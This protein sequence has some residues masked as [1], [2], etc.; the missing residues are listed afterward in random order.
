MPARPTRTLN[1]LPFGDLEPRRFEDLVRQLAYDLRTWKSLEATG[2]SGADDGIDIRGIELHT[3]GGSGAEP[4]NDEADAL[5][6]PTERLWI[7]QC[8]REKT[9]E[10]NRIR[11]AIDESIGEGSASPHGFVLAVAADVSKRARDV[12]RREMVKRGV[13]EFQ[14][15]AR[16]EL[17]DMLFQAKNDR[18]LFA[19]FGLSLQPRRRSLATELRAGI[20]LK[21]QLTALFEKQDAGYG[22][23]LV[24]LRD[25]R[26]EYPPF[27]P[28]DLRGPHWAVCEVVHLKTPGALCVLWR[29][30]AAWVRDHANAWDVLPGDEIAVH[31][32]RNTLRSK[33][34]W[35]ADEEQVDRTGREFWEEYVPDAEK[36]WLK[37]YGFVELSRVLAVD[38]IGD[39]YFPIPQLLM[40]FD[41]E[42]GPLRSEKLYRFHPTR[43]DIQRPFRTVPSPKT[44][45]SLF[46]RPIP[47]KLFPPP[48]AFTN[49]VAKHTV[50]L[51][52]SVSDAL[53]ALVRTIQDRDK[54]AQSGSMRE[55]EPQDRTVSK[56]RDAFRE[57][58]R[59][60]GVPVFQ[61]FVADLEAG[62]QDARIQV[63]EGGADE[64]HY[65]TEA[66]SLRVRLASGF[67][68]NPGYRAPGHVRVIFQPWDGST[69]IEIAPTDSQ[70]RSGSS[71][72]MKDLA[73]FSKEHLEAEVVRMHERVREQLSR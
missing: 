73:Q 20:T 48:P 17:E 50:A 3:E 49:P 1:P 16:G 15:W 2:R 10:P 35:I 51:T 62:G 59:S 52:P 22:E 67:A 38:P 9:F 21:K 72:R 26:A 46:P 42:H 25:A 27:G 14:I 70:G 47:E 60:I 68:M 66:V 69:V 32:A 45:A 58:A 6:L 31:G 56:G 63:E 18:L 44:R 7:F 8:K 28:P 13:Q 29:E 71:T 36:A 65:G 12:F 64:F 57:W 23:K 39:G 33:H 43:G 55:P 30:S 5:L 11:K 4:E 53:K 61:A 40:E 34:A 54:S 37:V 41:P 19:Y 24:L